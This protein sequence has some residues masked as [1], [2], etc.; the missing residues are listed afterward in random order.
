M[1]AITTRQGIVEMEA[2]V[3]NPITTTY[4]KNKFAEVEPAQTDTQGPANTL[5]I[6]EFAHTKTI[7]LIHTSIVKRR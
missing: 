1:C 2:N 6:T 5:Q 4:A 7:V 3:T